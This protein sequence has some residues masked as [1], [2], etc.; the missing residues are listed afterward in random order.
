MIGFGQGWEKVYQHGYGAWEVEQTIDGG[1]MLYGAPVTKTNSFGDTLWTLPFQLRTGQQTSDGGYI[2]SGGSGG[3]TIRTDQFGNALWSSPYGGDKI[4]Q[5][6][7]GGYAFINTDCSNYMSNNQ[8]KLQAC[9][10]LDF[11]KLDSA[12]NLLWIK[13]YFPEPIYGDNW[14]EDLIQTSD[15]GFLICGQL[16]SWWHYNDFAFLLKTDSQG[17]TLWTKKY[18]DGVNDYDFESCVQTSNGDFVICG[19]AVD[20]T[21]WNVRMSLLKTDGNGNIIWNKY[22]YDSQ[23]DFDHSIIQTN[24]GGYMIVGLLDVNLTVETALLRLLKTD[25]NGDTLWTQKYGNPFGVGLDVKQT[26][27]GGYIVT[28]AYYQDSLNSPS[29]MVLIK[30]N[31]LGTLSSIKNINLTSNNKTLLKVT[32]ILGRETKGKKNKPLFY[33]YNDGT[34]EKKIVIE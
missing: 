12:G 29:Q 32:D 14:G 15:G 1:Y 20:T 30:T 24:D 3:S 21:N 25:I 11:Y 16:S 23:L 9:E 2:F 22:H 10:E 34:V 8:T 4:I 33:I 26:I 5:T 13:T 28:G 27:D 6:N 17:D 31:S 7:D 19:N 18:R